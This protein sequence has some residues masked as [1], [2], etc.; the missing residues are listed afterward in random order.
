MSFQHGIRAKQIETSVKTPIA[1]S[2]GIPFIVGT[3]PVQAVNGKVNDPIL[4]NSY[5]E[6]VKNLGYND[7]WK[8]YSLCEVM[9]A[10]FKLY[11]VAPVVFVNVLDPTKHKKTVQPKAYPVV[12]RKVLLPIEAIKGSVAVT[13]YHAG[14]D[15]ELIYD[16]KNLIV[17][18]LESGNIPKETGELTI[19]FDEVDPSMVKDT[20]IIGGYDVA[21]NKYKGL[22]LID[23]VF[24]KYGVTCDLIACPGWSSKS[25]VAAVM[26]TKCENINGIFS[27]FAVVDLDAT[28]TKIYSETAKKKKKDNIFSK[29]QI[30]CWPMAK[31]GDKVFHLSTHITGRMGKTDSENDNCPA[32]SPSNKSLKID[33]TILADGTEVLTDLKEANY[34]NSQGIVTAI[35]FVG[36]YVAWGNETACYPANNDVKDYFISIGRMFGWVGNSVILSYWNQVDKKMTPRLV[37]SIVDSINIWLNGLVAEGKL[38]GGRVELKPEDNSLTSLMTGTV[39]F[40]IYLTPPSPAKEIVFALEYDPSYVLAAFRG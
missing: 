33:A 24:P 7:D 4:C 17:E 39:T 5:A 3:A 27:A 2:S 35:N 1:A 40:H 20:D 26:A 32:E 14:T 37:D 9:F 21:T 30:I 34:L 28:E 11:G 13:T 19:G 10:Q 36:G 25:L 22:E 6:A 16:E 12:E 31:L 23:K 15:Y 29:Y 8:K 38:L 18:I